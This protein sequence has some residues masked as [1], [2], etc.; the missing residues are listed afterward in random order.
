MD[1]NRELSLFTEASVLLASSAF[2]TGLWYQREL[3]D[4]GTLALW[5][6]IG[7]ETI[8]L[9]AILLMSPN[10]AFV[11]DQVP[12]A[13]NL[14]ALEFRTKPYDNLASLAEELFP[15]ATYPSAARTFMLEIRNKLLHTGTTKHVGLVAPSLVLIGEIGEWLRD[16]P[17]PTGPLTYGPR[18]LEM[19]RIELLASALVT[20]AA[21]VAANN[22]EHLEWSLDRGAWDDTPSLKEVALRELEECRKLR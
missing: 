8:S 7:L 5:T 12:P 10:A 14:R 6:S 21:R 16:I 22:V 13:E 19:D 3:K 1:Q 17:L 2:D 15:D 18:V 20:A 11:G 9:G 4:D